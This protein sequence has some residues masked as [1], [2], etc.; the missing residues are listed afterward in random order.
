M[1]L[2]ILAPESPV[3]IPLVRERTPIEITRGGTAGEIVIAD[4]IE[5][6]T[7]DEAEKADLS[8][9]GPIM[10]LVAKCTRAGL[11]SDQLPPSWGWDWRAKIEQEAQPEW[12]F[13][14]IEFEG[15]MQGMLAVDTFP[16]SCD[17]SENLESVTELNG[18]Y[19]CYVCA[20]PW[21]LGYYLEQVGESAR[22]VD[23]GSV[24]FEVA[25]YKSLE[26]GCEGRLI[27]HSLKEA[28]LFYRKRGMIDMGPDKRH[29]NELV[30][31]ELSAERAKHLLE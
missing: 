4:L 25:V 1:S 16:Q 24:L 12:C 5:E 9:E 13:F 15:L 7:A 27:L 19:L 3:G 23:I 10:E 30:R 22:F 31:F 29:P 8:W 2:P 14:G 20:A 17:H 11:R 6:L 28:E 21:N 26:C 18:L